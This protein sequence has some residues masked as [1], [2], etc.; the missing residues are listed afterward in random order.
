MTFANLPAF[1]YQHETKPWQHAPWVRLLT[2][3]PAVVDVRAPLE[4]AK[5]ALPGAQNIPLFSNTERAEIGLLYKHVGSAAAKKLGWNFISPRIEAFLAHFETWRQSGVLVY[6]ARGGLR[7]QSVVQALRDVGIAAVQLAGG[8]K[9][10]RGHIVTQLAQLKPQKWLVLQGRTGVGKTW[11]LNR[12]ANTIDLE[13][14]AQHRSSLFGALGLTPRTQQQFE[15]MLL[16]ELQALRVHTPAWIEAESRKI[17]MVFLPATLHHAM[18]Q[19]AC[20]LLT[21]SL[22]VRVKRL[23]TLYGQNN[24]QSIAYLQQ[25]MQKFVGL[26]GKHTVKQFCTWLDQGRF[27]EVAEA[28]LVKHYDPRYEHAMKRW[29][30]R[31]KITSDNLDAALHALK[32]LGLQKI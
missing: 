30:I 21:A 14:L 7:S 13:G 4:F 32:K 28:L 26:F 25:V 11:L 8:Y 24:P 1:P 23:V 10:I 19:S 15:A 6:C 18:Q 22:E 17:G 3:A 12:L 20:V 16:W 5:G 31:A 29:Q 9:A 2:C 27:A